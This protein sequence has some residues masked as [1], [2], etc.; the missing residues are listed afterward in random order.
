M[1]STKCCQERPRRRCPP[2]GQEPD[3]AA[4]GGARSDGRRRRLGGHGAQP[5]PSEPTARHVS[6]VTNWAGPEALAEI[7]PDGRVIAFLADRVGQFD[8]WVSLLATGDF[9]NL[10]PTSAPIDPRVPPASRGFFTT[11][12]SLVQS[13]RYPGGEK[14]VM[15]L[16][17]GT[18]RPFLGRTIHTSLVASRRPSR[19]F[20]TA[21]VVPGDL[22][23]ADPRPILAVEG[24]KP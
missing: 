13:L 21:I 14:L 11:D 9:N 5:R 10:T 3:R 7:S 2:P 17:G 1:R 12:R 20:P 18:P 23:G 16:T 24:R 22:P 8:V 6:S 15:P 19:L 4:V